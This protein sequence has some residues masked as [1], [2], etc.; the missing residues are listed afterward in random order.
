MGVNFPAKLGLKI[1][2]FLKLMGIRPFLVILTL[3]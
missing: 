1:D 3:G 2:T